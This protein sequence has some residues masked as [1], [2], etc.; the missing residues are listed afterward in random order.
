MFFYIKTKDQLLKVM[1]GEL[2]EY[3]IFERLLVA[4][5]LNVPFESFFFLFLL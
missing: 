1:V 2:K 5:E 3:I 4:W